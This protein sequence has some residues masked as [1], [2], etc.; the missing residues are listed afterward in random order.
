MPKTPNTF[1]SLKITQEHS[2]KTNQKGNFF[3]L[4]SGN[5][6]WPSQNVPSPKFKSVFL[7]SHC[8]ANSHNNPECF[9]NIQCTT[10]CMFTDAVQGGAC[11]MEPFP[12]ILKMLQ[13]FTKNNRLATTIMRHVKLDTLAHVYSCMSFPDETAS[14]FNYPYTDKQQQQAFL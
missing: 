2:F 9:S 4:P 10:E 11:F 6:L 13:D 7:D 8:R 14:G 5:L 12:F 1:F 3:P